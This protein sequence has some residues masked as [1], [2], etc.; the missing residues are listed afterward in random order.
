MQS[1]PAILIA[2]VRNSEEISPRCLASV[3]TSKAQT[4]STAGVITWTPFPEVSLY[5]FCGMMWT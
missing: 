2:I 4:H 3:T 1:N 5:T